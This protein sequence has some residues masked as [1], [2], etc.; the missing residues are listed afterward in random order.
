MVLVEVE[1]LLPVSFLYARI[2]CS[3]LL[4][5]GR[6]QAFARV[7]VVWPVDISGGQ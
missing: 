4:P 1:R 7:C 5:L 6:G 2:K 3:F